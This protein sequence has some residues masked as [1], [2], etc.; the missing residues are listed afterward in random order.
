MTKAFKS[1]HVHLSEEDLDRIKNDIELF[2]RIK[3]KAAASLLREEDAYV[4]GI[5]RRKKENRNLIQSESLHVRLKKE[6]VSHTR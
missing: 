1:R 3:H 6:F 2:N 5:D 4:P